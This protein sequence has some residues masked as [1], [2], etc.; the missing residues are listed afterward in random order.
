[1]DDSSY[2]CVSDPSECNESCLPRCP[3]DSSGVCTMHCENACLS[4]LVQQ[5]D[6]CELDG[7]SIT[8]EEW[9]F[10]SKLCSQ[11]DSGGVCPGGNDIQCC[12]LIEGACSAAANEFGVSGLCVGPS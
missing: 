11:T 2:T 12:T 3:D 1:M 4:L 6:E 10:I 8:P 7:Y 9:E 5:C